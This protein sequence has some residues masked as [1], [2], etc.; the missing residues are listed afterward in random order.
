M[1]QSQFRYEICRDQYETQ[2]ARRDNIRASVATPV[3][4]LAFS[5][6]NLSVL[7]THLDLG[8]WPSPVTVAIVVLLALALAALALAVA[9]IARVEWNVVY[10]D[11]PDLTEL[12]AVERR[13]AEAAEGDRDETDR[14]MRDFM[15]A[16]YDVAYRRYFAQNEHSARDRTR[17]L[18]LIM[19]ALLCLAMGLALLPLQGMG[20]A[21]PGAGAAGVG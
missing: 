6:F 12:V 18:R 14:L 8:R 10:L 15:A 7:G 3:S 2:R 9:L 11:P 1:I 19:A 16:A 5:I 17:G 21:A 13:M 4:A 20:A